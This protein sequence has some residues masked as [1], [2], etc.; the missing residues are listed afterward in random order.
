MHS[1]KRI[2]INS[3]EFAPVQQ[4]DPQTPEEIC[5]RLKDSI[6][7]T[8]T[9]GQDILAMTV[10]ECY[11]YPEQAQ[12]QEQEQVRAQA[13]AQACEP[14][15]GVEQ[16][17]TN[18]VEPGTPELVHEDNSEVETEDDQVEPYTDDDEEGL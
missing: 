3:S 5:Q 7:T 9:D 8:R 15:E 18:L 4:G 13:Q 10:T 2:K 1:H 17:I 16:S 11:P 14:E 12:A 6:H